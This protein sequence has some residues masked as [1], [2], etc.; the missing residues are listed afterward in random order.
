MTVRMKKAVF[1]ECPSSILVILRVKS[2]V[3]RC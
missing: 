1:I 2:F 3:D